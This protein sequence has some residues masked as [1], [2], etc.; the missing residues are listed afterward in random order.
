MALKRDDDAE[1]LHPREFADR[2]HSG[3]GAAAQMRFRGMANNGAQAQRVAQ[4]QAMANRRPG[5]K[6]PPR[7]GTGGA[8]N[9]LPL[10]LKTGIE[11]LSG[12]N[13]DDVRVH[14]NSPQPAQLNA[15]AY[16]QGT[17]IHMAPGQE[18]H[19]PHEA[20]HV[21]QQKQGRVRPTMQF[22]GHT[23]INDDK[24]LEHEA[25][26]M[27]TK[28]LGTVQRMFAGVPQDSPRTAPISGFHAVVQRLETDDA[29][30]KWSHNDSFATNG[31]VHLGADNNQL[32][33]LAG[34]TWTAN[35]DVTFTD[36]EEEDDDENER[37][38]TLYRPRWTDN[39][40]VLNVPKD[41]ITTAEL[42]AAWLTEQDPEE[43]GQVLTVPV[44]AV[45]GAQT[46]IVPGDILF[47]V[48]T[49]DDGDFH[50]AGVIA[51]DGGDAVTMEADSS[52]GNQIAQMAPVF[53]MY[54]GHAG[55]RDSQL[56]DEDDERTYVIKFAV[57]AGRSNNE[58]LWAGIQE[59]IDGHNYT[60]AGQAAAEK[61]K[62]TIQ[63][64]IAEQ[65]MDVESDHDDDN[66]EEEI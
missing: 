61:I 12:Y 37:T 39:N 48:H 23:A 7:T 53:D 20:W 34:I 19:L 4:L 11:N 58:Q 45:A 35:G 43:V 29:G 22:A 51:T 26:V 36:D 16:A 42:V 44:I 63:Q 49:E 33:D 30:W 57:A 59:E 32:P 3:M 46:Q 52:Q 31:G 21:V 40:G 38:L 14:Y 13:M 28:A 9:G 24:G 2:P 66:D 6:I 55:F 47:H 62:N 27:G 8:H 17:H 18:R 50:G 10:Q 25:D 15:H 56:G 60:A 64:H 41:C 1:H 65:Q 5:R 54:A